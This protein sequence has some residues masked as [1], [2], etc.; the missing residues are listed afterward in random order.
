MTVSPDL[1]QADSTYGLISYGTPSALLPALNTL[2][3]LS[4]DEQAVLLHLMS[5]VESKR[6]QLEIRNAYYRGTMQIADLGIAIPPQMR[7]LKVALGWPRVCVDALD[8]RLNVEGFRFAESTSVDEDLQGLWQSNSLDGESQLAHIDA[9]VFGQAFVAVGSGDDADTP[10]ITVESPLDIAVEWDARTRKMLAALRLFGYEGRREATLYLPDQTIY[11]IQDQGEWRVMDRD[12]HHLGVVSLVRI[13][14]RPRSYQRDGSSEITPEIM[15]ITDAACRTLQG[16]E[17]AREFYSAPQRFILGAS[18]SDFQNADGTAKSGWETYIGRILALERDADGNLPTVGQF[19]TYD[20]SVFTKVI[21][22]YAKIM[23]SITGLPPHVLGYTTD[24]PASADAIR[25]TEMRL[26]LKADRK[27]KMF[28]ESWRDVMKLAL[29]IRDGS[30]PDNADSITTVWADTATP[31]PA[32]TTDAI[33]KQ[34][35]GGI[36]PATSDVTLEK[37]GYTAVERQRLAIDRDNDQGASL[38]Q[39]IAHSLSGKALRV[40]TTVIK[41]AGNPAAVGAPAATPAK[42]APT[43]PPSGNGAV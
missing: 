1:T 33:F 8:E 10:L 35:E 28:G 41:D 16:L 15:S 19:T 31:T 11:C 20:P 34:V 25:S 9:L 21:D 36:I 22:M 32:A 5:A 17:V 2:G 7:Q 4:A 6:Y 30:V 39:E 38:L 3:A 24:N 14:N 37:L 12:Q 18:E 42:T 13:A 29:L 23:S 40:D 43:P 26:K 27:T